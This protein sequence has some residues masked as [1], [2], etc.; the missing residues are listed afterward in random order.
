MITLYDKL[1][2]CL[3]SPEDITNLL[4][5]VDHMLEFLY[6][7]GFYI[8]DFN[9]QKIYLYNDKLNFESFKEIINDVGENKNAKALNIYQLSKIGLMAYNK[10][11]VD[12]G[13]N[14]EYFDF[15]QDNLEQFNT[16]GNIPEEMYDY[17]EEIF[18]NLN[19]KYFNEFIREKRE[20]ALANKN[21]KVYKLIG[22]M[23][24]ADK[25]DENMDKAAFVSILFIPG[26][27]AFIYIF[28]LV[29]YMIF[30]K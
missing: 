26:I 11:V 6:N 14:Q 20:E 7:N 8:Y 23:G 22:P 28:A 3:N 18:K 25:Q 16:S 13:M 12:G 17:Y 15:I 2:E 21:A 30:I 10:K 1:Y 27:L 19:V 9:P 5:E 29:L 4:I 24:E